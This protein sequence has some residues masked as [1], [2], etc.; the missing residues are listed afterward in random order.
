MFPKRFFGFGRIEKF[1]REDTAIVSV[2][3]ANN[4]TGIL[5]PVAEIAEIVKE[6]PT[7]FFTLTA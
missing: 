1:L 2:M 5:F 3:L 7:R 4:E 6:I